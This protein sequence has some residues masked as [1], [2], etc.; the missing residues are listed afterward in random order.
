MFLTILLGKK[1]DKKK[2]RLLVSGGSPECFDCYFILLKNVQ[3]KMIH[4]IFKKRDKN[5]K[6]I[7]SLFRKSSRYVM[8]K[9]IFFCVIKVLNRSK[10]HAS[11]QF[12][13]IS[14]ID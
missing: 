12:G 6:I 11:I 8:Y 4:Q 2:T 7:S 13:T 5:Q 3:T 1:K 14:K 9:V 10:K